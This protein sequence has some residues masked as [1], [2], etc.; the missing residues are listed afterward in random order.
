LAETSGGHQQGK[1]PEEVTASNWRPHRP[2][3]R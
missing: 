3:P 1:R 2:A